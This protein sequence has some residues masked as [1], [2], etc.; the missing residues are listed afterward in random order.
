METTWERNVSLTQNV[1]SLVRET[2]PRSSPSACSGVTS[3]NTTT[4]CIQTLVLKTIE[5]TTIRS[6]PAPRRTPTLQEKHPR[7]WIEI[8]KQKCKKYHNSRTKV[9]QLLFSSEGVQC[10][11]QAEEAG[12]AADLRL[13]V[14]GLNRK[15][16]ILHN[17]GC[18]RAP[19]KRWICL[20]I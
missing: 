1:A 2:S 13:W 18:F 17:K 20:C 14:T 7:K 8:A 3:R 12:T 16:E 4:S 10:R 6:S 5:S 9:A 11:H 15:Y 19:G